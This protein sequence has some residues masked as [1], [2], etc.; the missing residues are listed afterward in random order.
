MINSAARF[1]AGLPRG[2]THLTATLSDPIF[3]SGPRRAGPEGH[4]A[5]W[6]FTL[7]A[8][9]RRAGAPSDLADNPRPPTEHARARLVWFDHPGQSKN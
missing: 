2:S 6:A 7:R 9:A 4:H 5:G 3:E 8:P 1:L